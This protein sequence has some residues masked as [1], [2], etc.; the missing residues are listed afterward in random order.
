MTYK[1]VA[2]RAA[3]SDNDE[4]IYIN[5][6]WFKT[7]SVNEA[8]SVLTEEFGHFL[9]NQV[10]SA[11]TYGDEGYVFS[12]ILHLNIS[13]IDSH[14]ISSHNDDHITI[15]LN[16][17]RRIM[18]ESS[19]FTGGDGNDTISGTSSSDYIDG[20]DG[21]DIIDG[22][23]GNDT[24]LGGAGN[25]TISGGDGDDIAI[26]NGNFDNYTITEIYYGVYSVRDNTGNNG[27]DT[28]RNVEK[29][30]FDNQDFT[31]DRFVED[32]NNDGLVDDAADY[33]LFNNSF[34]IPLKIAEGKA[35][36]D[37]THSSWDVIY[38]V[39]DGSGFKILLEGTSDKKRNT[40]SETPI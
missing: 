13:D 30:Q 11:D 8:I 37:S 27:V 35:L 20:G 33:H 23:H 5:E 39:Q 7:A 2:F 16:S 1:L 31:I 3:W 24:F 22:E 6:D 28:I 14:N 12:Q 32:V 4:E 38:A 18:A 15:T 25:D 29:L 21:N 40:K 9:D 26:Y 19:N 34:P 10:N 17:G 36:S